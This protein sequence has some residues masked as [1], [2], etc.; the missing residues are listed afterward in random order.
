MVE[1]LPRRNRNVDHDQNLG[2]PRTRMG[3]H[4]ALIRSKLFTEIA[5]PIGE[6][7]NFKINTAFTNSLPSFL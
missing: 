7:I 1:N 2:A 5:P 4:Y 3:D 6:D